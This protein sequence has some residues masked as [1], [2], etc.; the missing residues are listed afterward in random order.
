MNKV[1]ISS[2]QLRNELQ[3]IK[4]RLTSL[5]SIDAYLN[6]DKL[7]VLVSDAVAGIPQRKAILRLCEEPRTKEELMAELDF[8]SPQALDHH[9]NP[10][11]DHGII[12]TTEKERKLAFVRSRIVSKLQKSALKKLID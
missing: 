2:E 4:E 10:L 3:E 11:R 5:E 9:L 6:R 12:E 8:K 7:V 1:E